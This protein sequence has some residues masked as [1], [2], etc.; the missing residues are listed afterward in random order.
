M[1]NEMAS[2]VTPK[3]Y[4]DWIDINVEIPLNNCESYSQDMLKAFPELIRVRG[5]YD[6]IIRGKIPH[7]WLK[8]TEGL[9]IDPTKDQF[10][11]PNIPF[12]YEEH[13]ESKPEPTCKCPNCG[14]F[15]YDGNTCCSKNCHN[16]Y[17]T[18]INGV[19]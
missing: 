4:Q 2:I 19:I 13:D 12:F 15:C 9:I 16:E 14:G 10:S 8:T 11:G 7:W 1:L 3:I 5:H 6:E 17:L 18:Y